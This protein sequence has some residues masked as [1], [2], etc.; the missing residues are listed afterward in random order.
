M[1]NTHIPI[2]G[3]TTLSLP[4][5]FDRLWDLATNIWWTWDHEA[6]ELWR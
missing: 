1:N 3:G 2:V 6:Q 4:T 5:S